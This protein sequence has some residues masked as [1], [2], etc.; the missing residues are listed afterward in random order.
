MRPGVGA[1]LM[2]GL[3]VWAGYAWIPTVTETTTHE[4]RLWQQ[5]IGQKKA[6]ALALMGR[7]RFEQRFLE[8]AS[9]V[10]LRLRTFG[11]V[12]SPIAGPVGLSVWDEAF[13]RLN[14]NGGNREVFDQNR[15]FAGLYH[16]APGVRVEMGYL[17]L[18]RGSQPT[19]DHLVAA[20]VFLSPRLKP[21]GDTPRSEGAR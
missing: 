5:V 21:R 3:T 8:G 7:V 4:H 13:L 18:A 10:G 6:G 14:D 1:K 9:G 19:V 17:N 11:R 16:Q 12:G 20:Y 2:P 15:I